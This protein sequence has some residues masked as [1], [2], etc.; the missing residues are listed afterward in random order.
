MAD[1]DVLRVLKYFLTM[2]SSVIEKYHMQAVLLQSLCGKNSI[3][4]LTVVLNANKP[5]R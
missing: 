3:Q 4:S 1:V 5:T 2:H